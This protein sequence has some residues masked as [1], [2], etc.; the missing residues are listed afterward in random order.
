MSINRTK[1]WLAWAVQLLLVS[2]AVAEEGPEQAYVPYVDDAQLFAPADLSDYGRG[3]RRPEGWFFTAEAL[4]WAVSAPERTVVGK[5]GFNPLASDGSGFFVQTSDQSTGFI[6]SRLESGSRLQLGFVEN[7]AGLLI[8]TFVLHSNKQ[9]ASAGDVGVAF[10]SPFVGGIS[11][12]EAFVDLNLDGFDDDLNFNNVFGRDG[13]DLGTPNDEPPPAFVPPPDGIPDAPFPTDFGD[14]VSLPVYFPHLFVEHTT[15]VW[16]VEVMRLWQ[17]NSRRRNSNWEFMTGARYIRFQDD[18][19]VQGIGEV[20][21]IDIDDIPTDVV[22]GV[23]SDTRILTRAENNI[24]GPQFALRYTRRRGR[25]QLSTEGRFMP[26]ANMQSIRQDGYIANRPHTETV[27]TSR[28]LPAPFFP[29]FVADAINLREM[30]VNHT[31]HET[32]FSPMG[33][34]RVDLS[35]QAWRSV[36][37]NVGWTGMILGGVARSPNMVDYTLPSAGILVD[38]NEQEVFIQGVNFGIDVKR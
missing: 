28:V 1:S 11:M 17:W 24:V 20:F 16:G 9:R 34:F 25:L 29:S 37:F 5:E 32:E 22:V 18:F 3:P 30:A 13:I 38:N 2:V 15:R 27:P 35:Y 26:G 23:L 33:E 7:E 36:S 12:L 21:N 8:G 19:L 10:V 6:Q 4:Q 14:L 31:V